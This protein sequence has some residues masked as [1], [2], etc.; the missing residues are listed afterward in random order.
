MENDQ[1]KKVVINVPVVGSEERYTYV[2]GTG[3]A[4]APIKVDG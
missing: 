1:D 3:N 2:L 4:M